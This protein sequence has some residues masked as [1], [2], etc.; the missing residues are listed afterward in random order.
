MCTPL[1]VYTII[2]LHHYLSAPL[3]LQFI[4]IL[5]IVS[6]TPRHTKCFYGTQVCLV[7]TVLKLC[8]FY[9]ILHLVYQKKREKI[10]FF[11]VNCFTKTRF[12]SVTSRAFVSVVGKTAQQP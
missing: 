12:V 2:C 11:A 4:S 10:L 7:A 8:S 6:V 5:L 3:S 1:S 9:L